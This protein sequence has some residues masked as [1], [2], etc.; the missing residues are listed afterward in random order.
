MN[1][2]EFHLKESTEASKQQKKNIP[3]ETTGL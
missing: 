2:K 3:V 1:A